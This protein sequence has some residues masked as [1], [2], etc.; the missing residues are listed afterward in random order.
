ME[1]QEE[2]SV[3]NEIPEEKPGK[4]KLQL[5]SF[6][7]FIFAAYF[8]FKA[9]LRWASFIVLRN[10]GIQRGDHLIDEMVRASLISAVSTTLILITSLVLFFRKSMRA[11][12]ALFILGAVLELFLFYFLKQF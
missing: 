6:L 10:V 7:Y 11:S 12:I 9:I 2:Y 5:H 8:L 4:K 1:E 3:F